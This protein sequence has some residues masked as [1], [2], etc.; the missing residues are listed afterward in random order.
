MDFFKKKDD[1]RLPDSYQM[2]F[3]HG[4]RDAVT[5]DVASHVY[6]DKVF[7]RDAAGNVV[8]SFAAPVPFWEI[9]TVEDKFVH[10]PVANNLAVEF[11]GNWSKIVSY[12]EEKRK[13][14]LKEQKNPPVVK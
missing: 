14:A 4:A 12:G 1:Q 3:R 8:G 6:E 11:C 10:I 2:T 5:Y 13:V 9:R 7:L